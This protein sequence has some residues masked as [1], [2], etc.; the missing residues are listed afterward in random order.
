MKEID[1]HKI[2]EATDTDIDAFITQANIRL[3]VQGESTELDLD[4]AFELSLIL[5]GDTTY[6]NHKHIAVDTKL[7]YDDTAK[8]LVVAP[9]VLDL[10][11][12]TFQA[13][14]I[15]DLAD[16]PFIDLQV[17]GTKPNFD[18]LIA[19]APD[20]LIPTLSSYDNQGE[21]F[22][23]AKVVGSLS[24][25]ALKQIDA[26]FG[27]TQGMIK[28]NQ[29][30]RSL[31]DLA[32]NGYLRTGS[33]ATLENMAFGL[34]NFRAKPET[35]QFEGDLTVENFASP[36]IDLQIRSAFDLNFLVDFFQLEGLSDLSGSVNMTMNFH[37]IIDLDENE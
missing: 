22:F 30:T 26:K 1:L 11:G 7:D 37:D 34:Q 24:D 19:F 12:S 28:N 23:E 32:F 27:C 35:G 4:A 5:S 8:R 21:V 29:T 6:L 36:D 2:S 31:E 20:D 25:G 18:M 33:P 13:E 16:Y 17:A 9:S 15:L 14:G 3:A 10:E